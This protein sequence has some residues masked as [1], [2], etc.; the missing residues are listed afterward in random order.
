MVQNEYRKKQDKLA[1][2]VHWEV[3]K[4]YELEASSKWYEHEP[5]SVTEKEVVK[6]AWNKTIY[7]DKKLIGQIKHSC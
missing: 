3:S 7:T 1:L 6:L 2:R 4:K 5:L